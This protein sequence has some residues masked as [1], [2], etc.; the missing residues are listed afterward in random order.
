MDERIPAYFAIIPASV[1]YDDQ[2]PANAKLLYGEISALLNADGVC[3][4]S[5]AY[6]ADLYK[7]S[8]RT[9]TGWISA[10]KKGNYIVVQ[11][12]KDETGQVKQRRLHLTASAADGQPVENIFYTPGKYFR[13]GIEKIFQYTDISLKE[14]KK[15]S[16]QHETGKKGNPPKTDFDPKPL[17]VTWI[18]SEVT[19][20]F[21]EPL[22]PIRKNALYMALVWFA[23]N[24][25]AMKK[26]IPSKAAVTTLCNRLLKFTKDAA[27]RI[28]AMIDLLDTATSSGWQTVYAAK[29]RPAAKAQKPQGGRVYEEL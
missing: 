24:R 15:E 11:I 27:D 17:F 26:P 10:L 8:E 25:Q 20:L 3:F 4:A 22:P 12:D 29:D 2:I 7:V 18:D 13:E 19:A 5:N 16:P 14:N 1:R 23:E 9:I 28:D 21:A 6:F